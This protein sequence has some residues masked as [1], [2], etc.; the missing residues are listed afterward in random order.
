MQPTIG[1]GIK[2]GNALQGLLGIGG[3]PAASAAAF[4]NYLGS[5]NFGFRLDQGTQAVKTANAPSFNS[6][7]TAKALL[8]YGQ[9]LAGN[10]LEGYEGLLAGQQTLGA[11]SA[12][13]LANAGLGAGQQIASANNNAAGVAG[14]A[15]IYGA[16]AGGSA[17][18][19]LSSLFNKN[20]TSSSF[21]SGGGG[22]TY[23]SAYNGANIDPSALGG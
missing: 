16:N 9:G 17:L 3:D 11:N 18:S 12:V 20:V 22:S 6:G 1:G 15:G 19:G 8:G 10:A 5:T 4:K 7:A 23:G 13:G 14:A 2:A 21:G